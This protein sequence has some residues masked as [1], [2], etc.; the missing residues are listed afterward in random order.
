MEAENSYARTY[1]ESNLTVASTLARECVMMEL[2]NHAK[3]HLRESN[4]A[5]VVETLSIS[6]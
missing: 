4:F 5:H 3:K 6:C 1:V 2:V